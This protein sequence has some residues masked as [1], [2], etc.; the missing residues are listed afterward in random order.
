LKVIPGRTGIFVVIGF[1]VVPLTL[2]IPVFWRFLRIVS[3]MPFK[4][5]GLEK[6]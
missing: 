1:S 4:N 6:D 2:E 3:R 5:P